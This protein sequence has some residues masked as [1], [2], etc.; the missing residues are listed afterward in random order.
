MN[1]CE[2]TYEEAVNELEMIIKDLEKE[3]LSLNKSVK[4]FKRG[5]ELYKYC[6]EIL[7][8]VEGEI[9]IL[10]KDENENLMEEDFQTEV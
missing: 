8:S 2:L 3:D 4:K 7:N 6:N 1:N 10:L 9:K 5:V